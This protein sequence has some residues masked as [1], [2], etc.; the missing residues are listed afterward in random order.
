MGMALTKHVQIHDRS[1]PNTS[2]FVN[3]ALLPL[4]VF[5]FAKQFQLASTHG[6][7]EM[8]SDQL[9]LPTIIGLHLLIEANS[10][11][12]GSPDLLEL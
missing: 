12:L 3:L 10:E 4:L 11:L 7:F 9:A 5:I 2:G 6:M 8:L 1:D